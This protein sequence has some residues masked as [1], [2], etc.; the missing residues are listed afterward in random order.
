MS[1][2]KKIVTKLIESKLSLSEVI[3][4]IEALNITQLTD[5]ELDHLICDVRLDIEGIKKVV[6]IIVK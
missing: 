1:A 2:D 6:D 5:Y 3:R 4:I